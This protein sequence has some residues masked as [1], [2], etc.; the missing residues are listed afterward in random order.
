MSRIRPPP[1]PVIVP[2]NTRRNTL[3][4]YPLT[5]S[6]IH[7]HYCK[8]SQTDRVH[9]QH[10]SVI[11]KLCICPFQKLT[12]P[13]KN[14]KNTVQEVMRSHQGIYRIYKHIR[15]NQSPA[16]YPGSSLRP[17]LS[18][19]PVHSHRKYPYSVLLLPLPRKQQTQPYLPFP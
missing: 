7:S 8:N 5:N 1:T 16:Q 6:R 12:F 2:R 3:S 9:H 19:L 15:R 10:D 11:G 4:I 14:Q 13:I 18:L 17:Q